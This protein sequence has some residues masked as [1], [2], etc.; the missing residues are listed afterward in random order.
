VTFDEIFKRLGSSDASSVGS[1]LSLT[2]GYE[3]NLGAL[4]DRRRSQAVGETADESTTRGLK[5]TGSVGL[6]F[7]V[8]YGQW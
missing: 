4:L 6:E 2:G 8:G 5:S 1:Y 3:L 7:R